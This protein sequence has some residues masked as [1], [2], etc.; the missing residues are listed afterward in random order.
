[1]SFTWGVNEL[2]S[3]RDEQPI[4]ADNWSLLE[5]GASLRRM[6]QNDGVSGEKATRGDRKQTNRFRDW[7]QGMSEHAGVDSSVLS[8]GSHSTARAVK[9]CQAVWHKGEFYNMK[10]LFIKLT[11]KTTRESLSNVSV[12]GLGNTRSQNGYHSLSWIII[13]FS[14]SWPAFLSSWFC[15]YVCLYV[16]M[17][18]HICLYMWVCVYACVYKYMRTEPL[19][20]KQFNKLI[21]GIT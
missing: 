21:M 13:L 8:V 5:P 14:M 3:K 9:T 20:Y 16:C 6:H 11:L 4:N 17:C 1:M 10:I 7:E 18:V 15:V 12:W 19:I 2:T